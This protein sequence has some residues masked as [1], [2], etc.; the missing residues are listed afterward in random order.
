MPFVSEAQKRWYF[1]NKGGG[2][3]GSGGSVSF[4]SRPL[5]PS[6]SPEMK[7]ALS[8]RAL[9]DSRE[10]GAAQAE[11]SAAVSTY[12]KAESEHIDR[13]ADYWAGGSSS[14]WD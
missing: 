5:P 14:E 12:R 9:H 7:A 2:V 3:G 1:A 6:S 8:A 10:A 11:L 13:Q 4:S